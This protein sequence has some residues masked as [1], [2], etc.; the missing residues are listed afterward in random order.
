MKKIILGL[1]VLSLI[2][3]VGCDIEKPRIPLTVHGDCVRG[4]NAGKM[5]NGCEVF[6]EEKDMGCVTFS[7]E[8]CNTVTW[9]NQ[10]LCIDKYN[11]VHIYVIT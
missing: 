4:Y 3:L 11:E 10:Y 6:C 2:V 8:D 1:V 7:G 9:Q 5:S